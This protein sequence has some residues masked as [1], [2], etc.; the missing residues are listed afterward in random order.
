LTLD[1]RSGVLDVSLNNSGTRVLACFKGMTPAFGKLAHFI[2]FRNVDLDVGLCI[3]SL[4]PVLLYIQ[5]F[6]YDILIPTMFF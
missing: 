3:S 4:A 5:F 1:R 2:Y 6:K